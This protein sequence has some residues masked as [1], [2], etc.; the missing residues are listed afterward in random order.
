M[1]IKLSKIEDLAAFLLSVGL[2]VM[3]LMT[4]LQRVV[5]SWSF[6][7]ALELVTFFGVWLYMV[8]ALIA[9][10]RNGHL[11]VDF[12][13]LNISNG[14]VKV[15]HAMAIAT[16][17]LLISSFF[18]YISYRMLAWGFKMPQR[19]PA[20]SIPLWIPQLS[21]LIA[22]VGALLYSLR[23]LYKNFKKLQ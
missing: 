13:E 17:T 3:V 4:I 15:L 2:I 16:I 21:I 5:P 1:L 10:R 11:V 9:S 12:L 8:G 20:L 6:M 18:I 19:T 23:D 7:G 14:R 22:A